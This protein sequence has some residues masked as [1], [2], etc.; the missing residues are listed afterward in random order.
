METL[1]DRAY[2]TFTDEARRRSIDYRREVRARPVIVSD[3]D[4]VLQIVGNLLSNAFKV[5]P[6]GGR[7]ALELAQDNGTVRVAVQ[8]TGPGIA[9][10]KRERVFRPFVSDGAGGTGLGLAIAKELST[11]LGGRID[12]AS[13]LGAGSRFEL[14]LPA[15]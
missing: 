10:D 7:I 8:D 11:A 1:L 2:E 4:R 14:V 13:E 3:G 12:L 5:T 6:D 15:G 9:S